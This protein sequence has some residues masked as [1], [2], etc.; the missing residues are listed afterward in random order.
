M[1][2][3]FPADSAAD[4]LIHHAKVV[5][6]DSQFCT[7][8]AIAVKD[9]RIVALGEDEAVFK[10]AGPR[11]RVIDA[12]GRTVL[13]GLYDSHVHPLGAAT[14]ELGGALPVLSSLKEV[15]IYL[16]KK[17]ATTPEGEWLVLRYAFPTRLDE[18]RFPT[19][20]ELDQAA[21][22]HP[23]LYHA[24]PAGMVNS[25]ALKVSGITKETPNPPAGVVVK[26]PTT[27]EPTGMIRN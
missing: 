1:H 19:R 9:G 3:S 12:D 23:V 4:L 2:H 24:G 14:S 8:E 5:T 27:G 7:F 21:P 10:R 25:M 22:K 26:D 11:T 6:V 20:A 16:R 17:A 18:A 13:P 15:F